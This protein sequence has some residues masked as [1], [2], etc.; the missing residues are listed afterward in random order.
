MNSPSRNRSPWARISREEDIFFLAN[1]FVLSWQISV[2]ATLYFFPPSGL[3]EPL[4]SKRDSARVGRPRLSSARQ[5]WAPLDSAEGP[6]VSCC[7]WPWSSQPHRRCVSAWWCCP[8]RGW[9]RN[10]PQL[11]INTFFRLMHMLSYFTHDS[12]SF[13]RRRLKYDAWVWSGNSRGC[14][15][16][17]GD[18]F[19]SRSVSWTASPIRERELRSFGS[20]WVTEVR[21]RR[22]TET[23]FPSRVS[24]RKDRSY[25]G[26]TVLQR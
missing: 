13:F 15:I 17:T 1:S 21:F 18:F 24:S 6:L 23:R 2:S 22:F 3:S 26:W 19:E 5:R 25:E 14:R 8:M 4:A 10:G 16:L 20:F 11:Q 12:S 7:V 9:L